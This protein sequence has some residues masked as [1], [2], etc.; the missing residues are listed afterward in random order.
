MTDLEREMLKRD[1]SN[2]S[3][4]FE[5]LAWAMRAMNELNLGIPMD[6][7]V[8][9]YISD[10]SHTSSAE[11]SGLLDAMMVEI[12]ITE[13]N[14]DGMYRHVRMVRED[15]IEEEQLSN[16]IKAAKNA[17]TTENPP[18]SC[19]DPHTD[20]SISNVKVASRMTPSRRLGPRYEMWQ[21]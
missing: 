12:N 16:A 3:D 19:L 15:P 4:G 11:M 2:G 21:V 1:C 7:D 6:A 9:Q 13:D 10:G 17:S 8:F 18:P 20:I 5:K 14:L